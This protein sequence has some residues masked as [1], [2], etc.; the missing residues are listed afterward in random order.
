MCDLR[1][2]GLEPVSPALAGGFLTTAPPGKSPDVRIILKV[3][4]KMENQSIKM[5]IDYIGVK[6]SAHMCKFSPSYLMFSVMGS[7]FHS[8]LSQ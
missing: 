1:G 6:V 7:S 8:S 2:P 3:V 5:S 4:S